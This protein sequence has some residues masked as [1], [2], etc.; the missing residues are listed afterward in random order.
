MKIQNKTHARIILCIF[1]LCLSL[2]SSFAEEIKKDRAVPDNTM[3]TSGGLNQNN[4]DDTILFPLKRALETALQ[5]NLNLQIE[6]INLPV[7][8]QAIIVNKARFDP[9]LFAE[10]YNRRYEYQTSYALT[11][12]PLFRENE[13]AGKVGIRKL[14]STGLEAESYYKASRYRDNSEYEGLDPQYKNLLILSLR[15]PLLQ[16]F[17]PSVNTTDIKVAKNDLKIMESSFLLQVVNTIDQVE[18]TYHDLS[19]ALE[20]LNLRNESLRL[21]EKLFADNKKRFNAGLTHVGE[22]QEAETAV[23]SRQELVIAASQTVKDVT[24]VLKN[25]LQIQPGSPLYPVGFE[26]EGLLLT[27][28][29]IP[30]YEESFSQA[31]NNRPDY[32][33]KKIALE[34]KD[35]IVKFSKNQLLPRLDLLGTFGLNGLSG[36]AHPLTFEGVT[37]VNPYGG[38]FGDSWESFRHADGYEWNVGLTIDFPL[39]NR[40]DR[41]RYRQAKL[42]KEQSIL[43]LKNLEDTIDLEI[44][45]ALE[46]IKSS[47]DRIEVADRFVNLADKTL[48][49]EEE[50]M[51]AGLSDT[52]RILIFQVSFIDAKIRKVQ[53]LVDYQKA[54]AQLYRA[55]GTNTKRYDMVVN[56]PDASRSVQ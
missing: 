11:G 4:K 47:R 21:A 50:R 28:E 26:T 2:S 7:S 10:T 14:F 8:A 12:A 49:Q 41:A 1:C 17:G 46:N 40:A 33:Q 29:G 36:E 48:R 25:L 51:K 23:A 42:F 54:L 44:K 32:S 9:S 6:K 45:I 31:L 30:S 37:A 34:S 18:R 13:Q 19:G 55:M 43:D 20:T 5:N 15:Q 53:A 39:G 38:N 35:I 3:I 24:N 27:E 22:V 52:F 16:D 56:Y